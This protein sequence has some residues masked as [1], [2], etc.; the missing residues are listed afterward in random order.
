[1]VSNLNLSYASMGISLFYSDNNT[2]SENTVTNNSYGII[3][4]NS[5]ENR[6]ID[7]IF[8]S[9]VYESIYLS[10]S[11]NNE[12]R[13]NN[14]SNNGH[15]GIYLYRSHDNEL[16]NNNASNNVRHGINLYQ[17][18]NNELRNNDASNN[19]RHGINLYQ[20]HNNELRN[21][22]ASNNDNNGIQIDY[23]SNTRIIEN[24]ANS[25]DY[26]IYL[27]ASYNS[28][29]SKNT[30][31][32]NGFSVHGYWYGEYDDFIQNIDTS[33]TIN[34][35][36]IY[37]WINQH[38]KQVP[39][40]AGYVGIINSTNILVKDLSLIDNSAG[41]LVVNSDNSRIENVSLSQNYFGIRIIH[42]FN[43]VL[44][45]NTILNSAYGIR[46]DFSSQN[47]LTNN[48]I[49]DS[50]YDSLS[51]DDRTTR[52]SDFMQNIDTSNIVN[53]KPVYYWIN[54]KNEQVP[55]DAGFVGLV[56]CSN[57]IIRN[58]KL[59]N[60]AQGILLAHT[61]F[62]KIV[63]VDAYGIVLIKSFYNTITKNVL[64]SLD[65][66]P[67]AAIT[68]KW[69]SEN[70]IYFNNFINLFQGLHWSRNSNNIW[71]SP[72]NI[73]YNYNDTIHINFL[74]NYWIDYS[75]ND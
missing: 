10:G 63:D 13:N 16:R 69:S 64:H 47:T 21:N 31:L 56:N 17:S 29:L 7:N 52:L 6:L 24:T 75:E 36:P 57:I 32:N 30:M 28:T 11:H 67:L 72:T 25:N 38:N 26:G 35:K 53:G 50:T 55:S 66:R 54:R 59:S 74:G 40:D 20:S 34:G 60:T 73:T 18:H 51:F 68:F 12:L 5:D 1:N 33:N 22:D 14:A 48:I 41:V 62:S 49:Q 3:M 9:N 37:Y 44:S 15:H 23:S 2:V 39:S 46:F 19:V 45:N 27:F 58:V 71:R 61:N 43:I 4:V 8:N 70:Y 42:S 65:N